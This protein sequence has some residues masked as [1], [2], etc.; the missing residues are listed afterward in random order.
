[1]QNLYFRIQ[2]FWDVKLLGP[3]GSEDESIIVFR[4]A[5]DYQY[6]DSLMFS[7]DDVHPVV[8]SV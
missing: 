7:F 8:F 5:G 3:I 4:K 1:V 2:V 6:K